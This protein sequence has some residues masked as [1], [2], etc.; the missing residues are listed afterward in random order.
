M[1]FFAKLFGG[2]A[3]VAEAPVKAAE[4][5]KTILED[6]T[7]DAPEL[8]AVF[9]GLVEKLDVVAGDIAVD[10]SA[11]GLNVSADLQTLKDTSAAVTYFRTTVLPVIEKVYGQVKGLVPAASPVAAVSAAPAGAVA[12]EVQT[13]PGLHTITQG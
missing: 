3:A 1:T 7:E 13:G 11:D 8:R 10:V 2:A 9:V 12:S 4:K 6:A 5:I